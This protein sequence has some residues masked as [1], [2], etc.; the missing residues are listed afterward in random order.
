MDQYLTLIEQDHQRFY[1]AYVADRLDGEWRPLADTAE[2]PFASW[3]NIQ[4]APGVEP[5]TDNISHGE[6]IRDSNDETLAV[7]PEKLQF[8]FQGL[9]E[10]DKAD[11]G[12]GAFQWRLGIL[13][14]K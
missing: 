4:P 11:K 12:Y 13:T 14:P 8:L 5:W 9:L 6:L 2:R 7:D 1:K 3:H 10:K